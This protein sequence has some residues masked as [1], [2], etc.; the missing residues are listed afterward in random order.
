MLQHLKYLLIFITAISFFSSCN[1]DEFT[2]WKHLNNK[3]LEEHANDEGFNK[4]ESGLYYKIIH[5][6]E[7]YH[8]PNITSVIKVEYTGKLIDG[9]KFESATKSMYLYETIAGWQEGL[10]LMRDGSHFIFYIPAELAY[11]EKAKGSVPPNSVLI[12]DIKLLQSYD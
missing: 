1:E 9:T 10:R 6:S 8:R 3:W 12:F 4:T 11:G 7:G 5:K 2:D